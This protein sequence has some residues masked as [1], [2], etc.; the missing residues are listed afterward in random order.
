MKLVIEPF[1]RL[2]NNISQIVR[3]IQY[4]LESNKKHNIDMRLLKNYQQIIF[5][6]FPN[7]FIFNEEEDSNN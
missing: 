2:G 1:G 7:I 5:K 3:C 4:N 6:N